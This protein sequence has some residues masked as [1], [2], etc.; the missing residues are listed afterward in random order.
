[1]NEFIM[2]LKTRNQ[3]WKEWFLSLLLFLCASLCYAQDSAI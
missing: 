2:S 3:T 1:M